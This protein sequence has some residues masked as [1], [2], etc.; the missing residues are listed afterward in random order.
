MC[1]YSIRKLSC[2][3][4]RKL[5]SFGI[6]FAW[7][8]DAPLKK[9]S[10]AKTAEANQRPLRPSAEVSRCPV[11]TGPGR[12]RRDPPPPPGPA[13]TPHPSPGCGPHVGQR[14]RGAS[15]R[16]GPGPLR[17]LPVPAHTLQ[18]RA[19]LPLR[20]APHPAPAPPAPTSPHSS[21]ARSRPAPGAI[22]CGG[23]SLTT[24]LAQDWLR[25]GLPR[26]APH[27]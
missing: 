19:A 4:P 9:T 11:V 24:P 1:N 27:R 15:H 8:T 14:R 21:T 22:G 13:D 26:S 5:S 6:Q 2:L 10:Y 20:A 12:A 17:R 7:V 3:R 25:R 23:P 18:A 16:P